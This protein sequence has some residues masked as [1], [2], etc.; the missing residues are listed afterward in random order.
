MSKTMQSVQQ[1]GTGGA[2]TLYI[3]TSPKPLVKPTEVL[4]KVH[5]AG[6]NR[7][8]ILQ[9]QGKY[10]PPKGASNIL[11]LEV[12]GTVVQVGRKVT[13][14]TIGTRVMAL[15]AGGGQAEFV[16]V[17]Y[18]LVM[19]IPA[20]LNLTQAAALP[21]VFLT[22]YQAL[23]FEGNTPKASRVLIHAGGSGV[24]TAAIQLAK[25]AQCTVFTTS[26]A[27]K[28]PACQ[29]LGADVCIDYTSENFA[30]VI[31]EHTK[32]KG[33]N[34]I[35][36][37]IGAPYFAQNLQCLAMDGLLLMISVMG[38]VKLTETNLYPLLSKRLKLQGTTLRA[39]SIL[40]KEALINKFMEDIFPLFE[41]GKIHPVIDT[42]LDWHQIA[43]AHR[44]MEANKNTGKIILKISD[45]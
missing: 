30:S 5:F 6:L 39:R 24:G 22:A 45:P 21:E 16:A 8:D 29:H 3:G 28:I 7:A 26:S 20:P 4:I 15:L 34:L 36:D 2:E 31:A 11:G 42:V 13:N 18:R 12:S 27:G 9:R 33:V 25:A 38:G 35:L 14:L 23:F 40:Y 10:P 19:P 1:T 37:F 17:D 32:G 43:E 41:Q 44:Y